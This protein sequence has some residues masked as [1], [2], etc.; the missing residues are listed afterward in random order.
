MVSTASKGPRRSE[1]K[2]P[3]NASVFRIAAEVSAG[4]PRWLTADLIDHSDSGLCVA[5]A[6]PLE[7]GSRVRARGLLNRES[8]EE[9]SVRARVAWCLERSDGSFRAG[10]EY[11]TSQQDDPFDDWGEP[12]R[13]E[14]DGDIDYYEVLQL[15]QCAD[16]DTIFRV[17]RL[18]A[19][20]YHPDNRETGDEATFRRILGAYE[21]LKDPERKA[22]YD[23]QRLVRRRRRWRI[24][25][26]HHEVH[27]VNAERR[28]RQGLLE[29]LY[30][31]RLNE[32]DHPYLSIHELEDL[33]AV[34]RDHLQ[35]T[36]WYLREKD[37]VTRSDNGRYSITA[38]GFDEAEV[39]GPRSS[40]KLKRLPA[41]NSGSAPRTSS[42]YDSN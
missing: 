4:R 3:D 33:L 5:L 7:V 32:P 11:E 9:I 2:S 36:L 40:E 42:A 8:H 14:A 31:Q 37:F 26:Q 41:P 12:A 22:A 39:N 29:L 34:P 21:V 15:S 27:G 19:Q 6:T 30:A 17:F 28:Q 1:R 16:P 35:V 38:A 13:E 25:D 24:F 20:R 10:L 23:A 18:L